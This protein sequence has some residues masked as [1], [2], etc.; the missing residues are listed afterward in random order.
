[1]AERIRAFEW[2]ATPLGPIEAWPERLKAAVD[3]MLGSGF[4]E[5]VW[6]GPE[7]IQLYNDA[8]L[9]IARAGRPTLLGAPAR[10]A[11][12]DVWAAIG[13]LAERVLDAGRAEVGEDLPLFPEPGGER[14]TAYF[15]FCYSALRDETGAVAGT[16]ATAIEMTRRVLTERA[17]R[18]SQERQVF[19]LKLSD[20]LRPLGDPLQIQDEAA[21][22]LGE[23]LDAD[24]AY[25]AQL[26]ADREV[27][28]IERGYARPGAPSV[29]GEHA[30]S[31]FM[32][33]IEAYRAGKAL[34]ID[35]VEAAP[36]IP[37]ADLPGYRAFALRALM[38]A[39]LVKA[40]ELVAAMV[41]IKSTPHSWTAQEISLVHETAERTWAAVQRGRAE[42]E[43]R[44]SEARLQAATDLAGLAC[45][46]WNPQTNALH[47]DARVKALWGL[48]PDAKAD[49]ATWLSGIHPQDRRHVE[50]SL[51]RAIDPDGD[52]I[53]QMEY[54][55]IGIG[56]GVER[57]ISSHGRT[58]FEDRRPIGFIGAARD[59]THKRL[60]EE[61]LQ[62]LVGELQH[63]T[64]NLLGLVRA[65]ADKT[66]R[67]SADLKDFSARFHDRLEAMA[68]VQGLVSRLDDG[69]R[70]T[71]DELIRCELAAMAADPARITLEGPEG[72]RLRSPTVE[73]LA[74]ALHEL[75]TNAVKYG[76]LG[77]AGARLAV[78]WALQPPTQEAG[79]RLTIDWR[80]RGV[81]APPP[82]REV[83]GGGQGRE[84]IERALP[85]QLRAKTTYRLTADGVHCT[86]ETPISPVV[87]REI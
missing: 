1:M 19:L 31:A 78:T 22:I 82:G 50:A 76:A 6:W 29:V 47:W 28:V 37:A 33:F 14:R 63:R 58:L 44:E 86:I 55:V 43:L 69:A 62:V 70:I 67:S 25:Y 85:Y 12:A 87:R 46:T 84:L 35:D 38:G 74:M 11:W 71:F 3:T 72:V 83:R 54:R 24:R 42:M 75:A 15:T 30:F 56:D 68:R 51:L 81:S 27:C 53:C 17:L 60:S 20:A 23:H 21:R 34:I 49:Y 65:T 79:P 18:E 57:W 39:P 45:Y 2:S 52:G 5:F 9:G 64:R 48:P 7:L 40:G 26:D 61:R 73:T 32:P 36:S 4:A 13:P 16:R 80:E 77:Q 8:A 59:I 10:E 41:V 66:L